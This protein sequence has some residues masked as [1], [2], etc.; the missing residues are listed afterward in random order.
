LVQQ[1]LLELEA[2]DAHLK[3]VLGDRK[4][5]SCSKWSDGAKELPKEGMSFTMNAKK[6][7]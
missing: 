5:A 1:P 6:S 4:K 2:V 7:I 3:A